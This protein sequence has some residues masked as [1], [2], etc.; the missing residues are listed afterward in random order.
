MIQRKSQ[1]GFDFTSFNDS[2][3]HTIGAVCSLFRRVVACSI[4]SKVNYLL[5]QAKRFQSPPAVLFQQSS[6]NL[7]KLVVSRHSNLTKCFP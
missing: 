1:T 5:R 2:I 7:K 6:C 3:T 4:V